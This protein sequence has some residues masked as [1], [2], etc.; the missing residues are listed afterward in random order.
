MG[1]Y[2]ISILILIGLLVGLIIWIVR[3]FRLYKKGKK[4]SFSIQVSILSLFVILLTW[5]LQ[6]FPLSKNFYIQERTTELTG[7]K[8]WCWKEFDYEEISAPSEGYSLDIFK[9]SESTAEYFKNPDND[10]FTNF[11]P[12]EFADI[13]WTKTPVNENEQEILEFVTP[14]YI[15]WK[16]KIV[17]QQNFIRQIA[18]KPGAYYSY[19]VKGGTDFYL[20]DPEKRLVILINHN[21]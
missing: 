10:F 19:K 7:L 3:L 13:K 18:S 1:I 11:P 17:D 12:K 8:F 15:G 20:I 5:E 21:M 4:I 9:F 2:L 16:G 14:I 6:I